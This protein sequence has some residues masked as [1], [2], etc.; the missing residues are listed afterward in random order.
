MLLNVVEP[1]SICTP[2]EFSDALFVCLQGPSGREPVTL[3]NFVCYNDLVAGDLGGD[4]PKPAMIVIRKFA[5][6]T[7]GITTLP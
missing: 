5:G 3:P 6:I 4:V 1:P 2:H 7:L